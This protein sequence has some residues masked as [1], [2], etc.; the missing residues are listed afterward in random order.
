MVSPENIAL[1]TGM[2]V[3]NY[4]YGNLGDDVIYG[5]DSLDR[6]AGDN[7]FKPNSE[8]TINAED[9]VGGNDKINGYGGNDHI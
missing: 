6:L 9:L 7:R 3:S 4:G 8:D 5:T 2:A 1:E